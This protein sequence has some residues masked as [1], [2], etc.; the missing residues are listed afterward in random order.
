M[1]FPILVRLRWHLYIESAPWLSRPN[2]NRTMCTGTRALHSI[3]SRIDHVTNHSQSVERGKSWP[4]KVCLFGW[5]HWIKFRKTSIDTECTHSP[6]PHTTQEEYNRGHSDIKPHLP[7]F[8]SSPAGSP[9]G[10]PHQAPTGRTRRR[11]RQISRRT[12][13]L[14]LSKPSRRTSDRSHQQLVHNFPQK[15]QCS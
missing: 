13:R 6:S 5:Y 8:W 14:Q 11:T 2:N 3:A 9:E 4:N 7:F 10:P 15:T 1:G 12:T